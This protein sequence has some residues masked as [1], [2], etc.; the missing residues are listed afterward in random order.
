MF[1]VQQ[2]IICELKGIFFPWK[3]SYLCRLT[4]LLEVYPTHENLL[5]D[6]L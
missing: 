2:W 1:Q 5:D 6:P 3:S 4:A